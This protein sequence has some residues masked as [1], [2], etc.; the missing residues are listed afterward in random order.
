[1]AAHGGEGLLLGS[2]KLVVIKVVVH[3]N[4]VAENPLWIW[5]CVNA[6]VVH[7]WV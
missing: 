1:M 6:G 4:F 2:S 7:G 3:I 5:N